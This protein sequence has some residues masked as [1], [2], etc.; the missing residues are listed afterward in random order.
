MVEGAYGIVIVCKKN[1]DTDKVRSSLDVCFHWT[2]AKMFCLQHTQLANECPL[3]LVAMQSGE[4][5]TGF[6]EKA[7]YWM[8]RKT[9]YFGL[10]AGPFEEGHSVAYQ[11]ACGLQTKLA[12]HSLETVCDVKSVEEHDYYYQSC[13]NT[14]YSDR[15]D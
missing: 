9:R 1:N 8:C 13:N 10:V 4:M 5:G 2:R 11:Y 15:Q 12:H 3:Q 7:F 6:A 14:H